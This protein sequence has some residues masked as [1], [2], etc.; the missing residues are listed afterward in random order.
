[1][2]RF[3][4]EDREATGEADPAVQALLQLRNSRR[5]RDRTG[6][7]FTE[8]LRFLTQA[9]E[10]GAP[11]EALIRAP[12]L[13]THPAGGPLESRLRRDGVPVLTVSREVFERIS[14]AETPQGMAAVVRQQWA[15]L[16]QVRPS[17]TTCWVALE[18]IHSPGNLGSIL[19]TCDCVGAAG[20]ILLGDS[21]DPYDPA[22]VRASMGALFSRTLV[23]ASFAE[24]AAWKGRH[25]CL[26]AGTSP[27]AAVDYR[28][29]GY[30]RPTVLFLGSEQRG[31]SPEQMA[32]CDVLV[33]IPMIGGSDSLNVSVAAGVMLY[34][35]FNQQHPPARLR[36]RA[37]RY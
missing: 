5:E 23:R 12:E 35:I 33:H 16:R 15:S 4:Y 34:E 11:V 37:G 31:L 20:V 17:G 27:T 6:L 36:Q 18:S 2:P 14:L 28:A 13:L 30:R 32:L 29:A 7:F 3:L 26:L 9:I 24:F 25:K 8:G 22:C 1:M 19:R 21:V 10:Y